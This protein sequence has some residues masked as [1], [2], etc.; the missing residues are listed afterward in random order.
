MHMARRWFVGAVT[1]LTLGGCAAPTVQVGPADMVSATTLPS[2]YP[3]DGYYEQIT[4]NSRESRAEQLAV[5]E[6][7][8]EIA[9]SHGFPKATVMPYPGGG[10]CRGGDCQGLLMGYGSLLCV[11]LRPDSPLP[12]PDPTTEKT[13]EEEFTAFM[14]QDYRGYNDK[15]ILQVNAAGMTRDRLQAADVSSTPYLKAPFVMTP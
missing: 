3:A 12:G 5:A 1:L 11:V 13:P 8:A 7:V 4:I 15:L 2:R 10:P 6:K 9:R 14:Q